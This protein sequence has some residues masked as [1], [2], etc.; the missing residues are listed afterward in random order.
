MGIR[1]RLAVLAWFM[2]SGA[3]ASCLDSLAE[4]RLQSENEYLKSEDSPFDK[5]FKSDFAGFSYFKGDIAYCV[6]ASFE[7]SV[8]TKV[9]AM[10]SFNGK[11][12]PFRKYGVF[13]FQLGGARRSL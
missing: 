4:H 11:T 12:L 1:C 6:E 3:E 5:K 2:C 10:P 7:P 13:H 9:F 8:D